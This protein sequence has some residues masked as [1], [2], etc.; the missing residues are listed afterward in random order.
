MKNVCLI[1]YYDCVARIVIVVLCYVMFKQKGN[2]S[3]KK[4]GPFLLFSL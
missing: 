2:L 1:N 4:W 3:I